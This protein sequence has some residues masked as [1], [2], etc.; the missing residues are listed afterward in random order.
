[1]KLR[2]VK[3]KVIQDIQLKLPLK[4]KI[5]NSKTYNKVF[6]KMQGVLVQVLNCFT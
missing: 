6:S 3:L 2:P 4:F 5:S 1:M